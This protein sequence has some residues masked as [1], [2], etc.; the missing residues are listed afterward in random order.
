MGKIYIFDVDGT[1]YSQKKMH[2]MMLKKL[3]G[4]YIMHPFHVRDLLTIYSFRKNRELD[5]YKK[6]SVRELADHMGKGCFEVIDKWLFTVPL[7]I[8][9]KCAYSELI[10]FICKDREAKKIVIYSDYPAIDKLKA[11]GIE[12]DLVVTAD[13]S[14]IHELKPSKKAMEYIISQMGGDIADYVYIGDRD[15]KDGESARSVGIRYIDINDFRREL[16]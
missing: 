11:L 15:S 1:L 3:M 13:D 4:Y 5:E 7:E 12:A 6:M 14:Q 9:K 10:D 2:Y 16:H 8:I